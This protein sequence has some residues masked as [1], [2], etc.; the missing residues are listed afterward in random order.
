MKKEKKEK[1]EGTSKKQ[2]K[3]GNTRNMKNSNISKGSGI[4]IKVELFLPTEWFVDAEASCDS[5]AATWVF[6]AR[7]STIWWTRALSSVS[8]A[9]CRC[10]RAFKALMHVSHSATTMRL[11]VSL[12][13][14][15]A[16]AALSQTARESHR[17]SEADHVFRVQP[18]LRCRNP[19]EDTMKQTK[20]L[21]SAA[22]PL[23]AG[24]IF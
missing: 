10:R 14:N 8:C 5:T 3:M 17:S 9:T 16:H 21:P 19:L 1:K 2:C 6:A 13:A 23:Q 12:T 20:A 15:V 4:S 24:L 11:T 7:R 18:P 22:Q